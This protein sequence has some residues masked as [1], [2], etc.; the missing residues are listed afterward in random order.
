MG[1]IVI[2]EQKLQVSEQ[3]FQHL[4]ENSPYS[5]FL[6]ELNGEIIDCNNAS[7]IILKIKKEQLIGRI[8]TNIF[9]DP[10]KL[11]KL[12][13]ERIEIMKKGKILKPLELCAM[14]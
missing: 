2:L 3:R 7:E 11:S 13:K 8:F 9:P 5:V 4:F 12:L 1:F 14:V 6:L 10:S